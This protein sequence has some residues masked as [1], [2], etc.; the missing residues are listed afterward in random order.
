M[1]KLNPIERSQHINERYKSYI[2]SSFYFENDNIQKLFNDQLDKENLFK[3]PYVDLS[4]PFRR[5][6]SIRELVES[7]DLCSSFM[8]LGDINFD[9]PLYLHQEQSIKKIDSG[10]GAIVTTG[11]GSGKTECFLYP[12][13]NEILK[14]LEAGNREFG[15]RAIFLYPMNALVN[16]QMERVRAILENYPEIRYGFFTGDTPEEYSKSF[17]DEY[18]AGARLPKNEIIFRKDLRENPP[19]LLFT[20]YSMLEYLMIRPNDFAIFTPE[21]LKNWKYIVLDEAHTYSGAQGIEVSVLLRRVT[22]LAQTKPR[23]I[24][25]SATLGKQGESEEDIVNFANNLTSSDFIESDII[26]S[27]RENVLKEDNNYSVLGEDYISLKNGNNDVCKE[28]LNKYGKN[29][30]S[31]KKE[32]IYD[33]L[34][35]DNNVKQIYRL[36]KDGP[37]TFTAILNSF[38]NALKRDQLVALIDLVNVAAKDGMGIFDLKYHSFIRPLSGAY[39]TLNDEPKLT[40]TKTNY[41]DDFKAFEIGNCRYCN[42][43]YVF[44]KV[45][46]RNDGLD[47]LIQNK[48]VDIYENY[49]KNDFVEI[50]YFL[51]NDDFDDEIKEDLYEENILCSKCGAIYDANNKNAQKCECGEKY[52]RKVYKVLSNTKNNGEFSSNNINQCLCCGHKGHSGVVKSLNLGKDEGTAIV[53][54]F[55]LESMSGEENKKE[56]IKSK[57]SLK[58]HSE[59]SETPKNDVKQL[60]AF[61]DS[62]QQASFAASFLDNNHVRM[63]QK[64]LI[65]EA[66]ENSTDHTLTFDELVS[67]VE[68]LIK[69]NNLFRYDCM[70]TRKNAWA[71]LLTEL[72][73][74]DGNYDCEGLGLF[75]FDLDLSTIDEEFTEE[76]VREDLGKYNISKH[77]LLELIQVAL[78]TFKTVPA[79]DSNKST[80]E[81]DEKEKY[82]EFRRFDNSVAFKLEGK[83][84]RKVVHSFLPVSGKE[85]YVI[86]YVMKAL[87][88][89]SE[90]AINV[91]DIIFNNLGVN[92]EI[93]KNTGF[94][95]E[96]KIDASKYVAKSYKN[97]TYYYC[98][99]CKRLTPHNVHNTCPTDKCDGKLIAVNPDEVLAHN[100]YRQQ[101][102]NMEIESI[103][104]QEHTA[105]LDKRTAKQYQKDFKNKLIN[106]L[107]CSTTFEMG[108]DIGGL[109]TVYMRNIPPTPASY[110]QRAGRAGRRQDSSA[111]IITYCGASSHDYTYFQDPESMIA[112]VI[113][114]PYFNVLNSK[115]IYRHLMA[116]S[117]GYFFRKYPEYFNDVGTFALSG[118]IEKFNE[119]LDSNPEDLREYI[120][121]KV[122]PEKEYSSYH[123]FAWRK[124][125]CDEDD[126]MKA[127]IDGICK[128]ISENEDAKREAV[129]EEDYREASYFDSQIKKIKSQR[130][131][132]TFSQYCVIPKY[133][134]P[135]DTVGLDVYD[136][137]GH[138]VNTYDLSRD[139][140]IAISE[141]A[142]D[143]EIIVDKKKYTSKYITLPKASEFAKNYFCECPKCKSV[144][145]F[146][147]QKNTLTCEYCGE[148]ITNVVA[149]YFIDPVY[150]FKTGITKESGR[151]KPKKSY[152]GEVTYIGGGIKDDH[153]LDL[154]KI[155]VETS[156]DDELL[157][158]NKSGFYMCPTCGYADIV[159]GNNPIPLSSVGHK[160]FRKHDCPNTDLEYVRLGHKFRTDVARFTIDALTLDDKN[161][162]A[163]ALSFMYAFLEGISLGL[164]IERSDI[165]GILAVNLQNNSYDVL[166]YDC[167]PG[168]AGHTKRLLNAKALYKALNFAMKKVSQECCDENTSCYGCLRNYNNQS[169]HGLLKRVLAKEAIAQVI[170][171]V[172]FAT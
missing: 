125:S 13:L 106:V 21:R 10:R 36:L 143:S 34:V 79:I 131:I 114:P 103:V 18:S 77:D 25:T 5:G 72:L 172:G 76:D 16:D 123:N 49:G 120:D 171:D 118:G 30:S 139:L 54:Q 135:V 29:S 142:P 95:G 128:L 33:L 102:K 117:L 111:Y 42:A 93:L 81:P 88:C 116:A 64:R 26:F 147:K 90:D 157:I 110:V 70:S 112:G 137:N 133:G 87:N 89:N 113:N 32:Q 69:Q 155:S 57:L 45:L 41:I 74:V 124:Y 48:E 40:L 129:D 158:M 6:K 108:I 65:W 99:K 27:T 55:I 107:S 38:N 15:I 134:F 31:D 66:L 144:N 164:E 24:L 22:A 35:N 150:G 153:N 138:I 60:L 23:F 170:N 71:A 152:S 11:T 141:Y 169:Y 83:S 58:A 154:G 63:L 14:E 162:H 126:K 80:L 52:Q 167:V 4:L 115:I 121:I 56:S 146:V 8:N 75:Y 2:R 82:L 46:R 156:S 67:D 96:Y 28:I 94:I 17:V 39:L 86:R 3:G 12:I 148:Q 44:G 132:N 85:N 168:G 50:N 53:A 161:A 43:V 59:I 104:V 151:L 73:K 37:R 165:N 61:S 47:Y 9:R 19:H 122:I 160:N 97:N 98:D 166:V 136:D 145:V 163:R 109:E 91:L 1:G 84:G 68:S 51:L 101:Y 105:Q 62:R 130:I 20:N 92:A 100:F 159:H 127:F 149:Q 140:Q 7:G 78:G 119:Y